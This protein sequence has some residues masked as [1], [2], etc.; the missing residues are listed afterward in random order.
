MRRRRRVTGRFF[1][2]LA[3]PLVIILFLLIRPHLNFGVREDV[4]FTSTASYEEQR[5]CVFIRD[6]AVTQSN[7][8]VSVKYVARELTE[9]SEGEIIAN[10]YTTGYTESLLTRLEK[11]RQNIQSYHKTLL[12][13]IVDSTLDRLDTIIDMT[14]VDFKNLANQA[15]RANL[16]TV[17]EQLETAMVNRQEYLRQNKRDDTKLTHLYEEENARLGSI[18]SWQQVSKAPRG[19]VVSFYLDGYETDLTPAAIDS[20]S[21]ANI[22][23]VLDGS[24]LPGSDS[25]NRYGIYRIVDQDTWYVAIAAPAASWSPAVGE[26]YYMT[27]E[28]FEDLSFTALTTSVQN[29]DGTVLGVFEIDSAMGP[30]IYQRTGRVTLSRSLSSLAVRDRALYNQE[31]QLG[32]WVYDIPGG[33]FVPVEILYQEGGISYI[34]PLADGALQAGMHILLK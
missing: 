28:G 13:S 10:L 18:Q 32:V 33:T 21:P 14:A 9:V 4:I 30:L 31:G 17:V 20:L 1:L 5:E 29:S 23:A 11:T 16:L 12:G 24:M 19:G 22:R 15:T 34:R 27:F 7:S 26:T 8:T 3:I 6:E 25:I 2:F